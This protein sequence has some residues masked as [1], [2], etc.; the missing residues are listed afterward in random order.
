ME[1]ARKRTQIQPLPDIMDPLLQHLL[2][3]NLQQQ[4]VTQELAQ[5][6]HAVIQ[7]QLALKKKPCSA[8]SIPLPDPCREAASNLTKLISE[9]NIEAFLLTFERVTRCKQ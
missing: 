6:L 1:N 9:Y 7:E 2:E 8:S 5:S 4:V 3:T